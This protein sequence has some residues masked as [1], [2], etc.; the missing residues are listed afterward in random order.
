MN[1]SSLVGV[2]FPD[3][4]L[5]RISAFYTAQRHSL[6]GCGRAISKARGG[7]IPDNPFESNI[8]SDRLRPSTVQNQEVVFGKNLKEGF[9][10]VVKH[11]NF[12]TATLSVLKDVYPCYAIIRNPLAVLLSWHTIQAPVN[13]GR[14]P[15]GE[16]FDAGL[17]AALSSESDRLERQIIILKW[18]FSQYA[19]HL[20]PE[21]VIKYE[22]IVASGGRVLSIIDPDAALLA[23][24]LKSRNASALYDA[25]LVDQLANRLLQD[26]SICGDFYDLSEVESLRAAFMQTGV[27]ISVHRET[28][29]SSI[30]DSARAE[31]ASFDSLLLSNKA[32]PANTNKPTSR[33]DEIG[34]RCNTDKASLGRSKIHSGQLIANRPKGHDYLR[35]YEFFLSR[36]VNKPGYRMMELGAGPDWNIG[37]S[38]HLW[39]EYFWRSDFRLHVVDLKST[40][41]KLANERVSVTIG[42]LGDRNLLNLLA[43]S[44]YDVILDDASHLWI[45]QLLAFEILFPSVVPGGLYIIEDIET[46][47]GTR[48][49]AW[50]QGAEIDSYTVL[51]HLMALVAGKGQCHPLLPIT[52][53]KEHPVLAFW[54]NIESITLFNDAMLIAKTGYY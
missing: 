1:P 24:Q 16:A 25:G 29:D 8:V 33:M 10:L 32:L 46:S 39:E 7:S 50:S 6:L 53:P 2:P 44:A 26:D 30:V 45:H 28:R 21:H 13:Q 3:G 47:F 9:R 4:Y 15:Y 34:I 36:F 20:L 41:E 27:S 51:S 40:V 17:K 49:G 23:R 19:T 48:R 5:E 42:D 35:K 31:I 11:P 38:V 14:L 52:A 18:Y 22:E 12:F 43:S 37:A 54:S